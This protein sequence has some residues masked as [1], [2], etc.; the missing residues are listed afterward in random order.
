MIQTKH[1]CK[2]LRLHHHI[3]HQY[4]SHHNFFSKQTIYLQNIRYFAIQSTFKMYH[5]KESSLEAL[6]DIRSIMDRSAR[7]L[8]LSGWSGIWAGVTALAGAV[9]AR[10]WLAQVYAGIDTGTKNAGYDHVVFRFITLGAAVFIAALAG[11]FFF[12][13]RKTKQQDQQLWN[14]AS[15]QLAV[16]LMAPVATGGVFC[17]AF[18]HMGLT[19]LVAP[20][21]LAF[22][23]LALIAGSKY[24]LSEIKYLGFIEVAL[25]CISLLFPGD[26]LYF[27]AAGFGVLHILYGVIMWNKYDK[28]AVHS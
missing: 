18:I 19:M 7:F 22:Y 25:G 4:L 26:G 5:D 1:P 24:T 23:G 9:I 14:N 27:W 2:H 8:S 13:Y 28:Q 12:T 15:K 21:C 10:Q 17:I 6:H 16:Q 11:G 20:A 3:N